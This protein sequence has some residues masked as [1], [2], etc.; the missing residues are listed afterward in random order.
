MNALGLE[1][2]PEAVDACSPFRFREPLSPDMAATRENRGISFDR[3]VG[4]CLEHIEKTNQNSVL[5]IEGVGGVMVPLTDDK[6]VLDWTAAL[7]IPAILVV[8]SYL[9]TLSHTLTAALALRSRN[10]VIDRVIV[11][12]SEESPVPLAETA[13]VIRR[14]LGGVVV[15]RVGRGEGL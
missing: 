6:T 13:D 14:H 5:F 10:I 12:E 11:S 1:P 8:G 7:Q 9:G 15:T 2:T 4:F 3:L